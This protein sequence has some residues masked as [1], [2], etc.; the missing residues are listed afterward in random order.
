MRFALA[1]F[2]ALTLAASPAM[3]QQ[4]ITAPP[5]T[6]PAGITVESVMVHGASLEGNLEGNAADREAMVVLP[7]SYGKE[8]NRHYPVVYYLHGFAIDGR[9]FYNFMKVPEAVDH[10]AGRGTEFIVVVPDSLTRLGGSMYSSSVTTGDFETFVAHDLVAYIDAH[11]RTIP[12][13][14]GRGLAGHSMGG[15]GTWKIAMDHPGVFAAVWAQSACCVSPRRETVE[16]AA[17]LAA[18]PLADGIKADFG[19]RAALSSMVA[20][21]PNPQNAPY[22]ADFPIKDGALDETVLAKWANN[23]PLAMVASRIPALRSYDAIGADVGNKDGLVTDDT[24]IH[25]ELLRFGIEHDWAV[26][27]GNHVDH[28]AQRFDEV[29]LPFMAKHLDTGGK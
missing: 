12:T 16:S 9:N 17:K 5:P 18:L 13:R 14:E 22:Y 10:N 8:P 3:A 27:D 23:S 6:V 26:Y 2:A 19:T 11:Y 7:P 29:V 21:S 25:E 20:W 4:N 28:I 24:L 15:Y 1:A